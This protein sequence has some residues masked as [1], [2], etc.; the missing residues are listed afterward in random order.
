MVYESLLKLNIF[1]CFFSGL[2][3]PTGSASGPTP[4]PGA[5]P[6]SPKVK[7]PS[8]TKSALNQS[9]IKPTPTVAPRMKS[10]ESAPRKSVTSLG[11]T[12]SI[13]EP[14]AVVRSPSPPVKPLPEIQIT[15]TES[16]RSTI[17]EKWVKP[18]KMEEEKGN[19]YKK[20]IYNYYRSPLE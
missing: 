15:R 5:S 10:P 8:P 7:S 4:P 18:E 14:S 17:N 2:D 19:T 1:F 6:P 16:N 12:G 13:G 11:S 20:L 9:P 3:V